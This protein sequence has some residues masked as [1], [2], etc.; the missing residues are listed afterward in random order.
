MK[1]FIYDILK[2]AL[3]ATSISVVLWMLARPALAVIVEGYKPN[4]DFSTVGLDANSRLQV[5]AQTSVYT[6][7]NTFT[8]QTLVISSSTAVEVYPAT[9]GRAQGCLFNASL[10]TSGATVY[11]G[12]SGVTAATGMEFDAGGT[13]CPDN[14][15]SFQGSIY[16]VLSSS[17]AA[18]GN[19]AV[20]DYIFHD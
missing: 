8:A 7:S 1:R 19:V 12:S 3:V 17:D 2:A 18:L 13:Y 15:T 14:P 6:S 5:D 4:G 16:A 11:I 9:P 10:N 20:I